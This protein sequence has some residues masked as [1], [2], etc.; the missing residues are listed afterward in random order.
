MTMGIGSDHPCLILVR[1]C[2]A[3]AI[4][5]TVSGIVSSGSGFKEHI[6]K[7]IVLILLGIAVAA[8]LAIV[9]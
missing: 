6:V 8:L 7:K 4:R 9:T 1:F 3:D 5:Q 2:P